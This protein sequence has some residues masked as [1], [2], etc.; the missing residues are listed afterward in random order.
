MEGSTQMLGEHPVNPVLLATDLAEARRF[1]HDLLG[2]PIAAENDNMITFRTG[3]NLLLVS[4]SSTGTA[5]TQTQASWTVTDIHAE[6]EA[7]R[8]RGVTIQNIDQPGLSTDHGIA[9]A[10]FAWAAWITDPA[11]N[12]LSIL[13]LK[14]EPGRPDAGGGQASD[15]QG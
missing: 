9:D 11:G 3:P 10:G 13:Q 5:D 1:Y 14:R 7:L 2:L 8:A 12:S 15:Q 6:T 4:L